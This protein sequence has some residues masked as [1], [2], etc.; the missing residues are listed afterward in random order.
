MIRVA[1]RS[2]NIAA[3]VASCGE[4]LAKVYAYADDC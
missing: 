1:L 2:D 3:C 4:V